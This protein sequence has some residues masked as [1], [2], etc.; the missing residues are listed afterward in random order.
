[1]ADHTSRFNQ[2]PLDGF[3]D[4]LTNADVGLFQT[5]PLWF[6]FPPAFAVT[7]KFGRDRRS[8]F[9]CVAVIVLSFAL[10][11]P[12]DGRHGGS[13]LGNRYL[14]PA[15]ACGFA[16]IGMALDV[17]RRQAVAS[18]SVEPVLAAASTSA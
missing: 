14:F 7:V 10:F 8:A 11:M 5:A 16:V 18:E 13:T 2:D 3:V 15:L 6:L 12:Y 17:V 4:L 1:M 9:A